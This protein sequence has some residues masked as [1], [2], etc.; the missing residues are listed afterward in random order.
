MNAT[1]LIFLYGFLTTYAMGICPASSSG[2]LILEFNVTNDYLELTFSF[3]LVIN[4]DCV[5]CQTGQIK[6]FI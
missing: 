5:I 6:T 4:L 1:F 3:H 2:Y